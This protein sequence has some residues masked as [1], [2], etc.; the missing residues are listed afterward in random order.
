M[1]VWGQEDRKR[2]ECVRTRGQK[3]KLYCGDKRA[4]RKVRVWGQEDRMRSESVE[5]DKRTKRKVR[6]GETED[7]EF[8]LLWS[9]QA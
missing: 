5:M 6:V 4:G 2:S 8:V 1:R 3:E 9:L 7:K